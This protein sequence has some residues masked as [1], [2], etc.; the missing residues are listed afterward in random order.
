MTLMSTTGN[1]WSHEYG[2]DHGLPHYPGGKELSAHSR[3]G[4]WGYNLFKNRLIGNLDWNGARPEG[5]LPYGF[6]RDAM[7][8]G[9]PMGKISVFTLHT[10]FSLNMIQ[11]KV[12]GESGVLDP[13]SPTGYRKWDAK[14]QE[15]VVSEVNSP[16]PNRIGVPVMT[17]LGMYDPI[18]PSEMP[19]FIYPAL[20]GNWGN[21]F[22][23]DTLRN[24]DPGLAQSRCS[25]EVTDENGRSYVFPLHDERLDPK[26]MNQFHINL[27]AAV[28]YVSAKLV[29]QTNERMELDVREIAAPSGKLP[30]PVIVGRENGFA[31]AAVRLREMDAFLAPRGY[32]DREQL[33]QAMEDYYGPI[34]DYQAGIQFKI[35]NVYR[36]VD[37][38]YYQAGPPEP[39][40][41]K[42]RFR[43]LG[44]PA[45]YL[46]N[47]R[48]KIGAQSKD[49]AKE[50]MK[51]KSGVYYYVPVD[52]VRVIQSDAPSPKSA[53]WYAK[54][55]H[56]KMTVNAVPSKGGIQPIV[57]RGQINDA[58]VI[59][60][61]APIT[62]SSRV[63]FTFHPEDN[64]N[65]PA[66][67]YQVQ[68]FAYAQGWHDRRLI[69]SFRVV[70]VVQVK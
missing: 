39:G 51:G 54:G 64:P 69:E 50:V 29:V 9:S 56:S 47:K 24:S 52:H 20:Y 37:G 63:R 27:P 3:N 65:V 43:K 19:S 36:R 14:K 31:A 4:A 21:I 13:N 11:Q 16:K 10:P 61:G 42:V 62:E 22:S 1:E 17:L 49:Y 60:R 28:R 6:G 12:G 70:G 38:T 59:N 68:F 25:L 2:H 7:A 33:H 23:P 35:G 57:L 40:G 53:G 66:G 41:T 34:T 46:S 18:Q 26:I 67:R 8:G 5:D 58:H 45:R 15:M 32:P 55:E 44:D 48:L 30:A